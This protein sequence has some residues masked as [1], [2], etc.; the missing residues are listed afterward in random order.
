MP[1]TWNMD[2]H[3]PDTVEINQVEEGTPGAKS[4]RATVSEIVAEMSEC[5][6]LARRVRG[7]L[8][9]VRSRY[10]DKHNR[11]TP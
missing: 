9:R 8:K 5:L 7:A 4:W 1:F 3:Q 11:W 10:W 2:P 6:K